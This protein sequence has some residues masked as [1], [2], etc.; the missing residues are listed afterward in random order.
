MQTLLQDAPGCDF[1]QA[2]RLLQRQWAQHP[3]IGYANLPKDEPVRLGQAPSLA[4]ATTL[5]TEYRTRDIDTPS[6]L[7]L[8]HHGLLG[9]NG[10]L[11]LNYTEY[12]LERAHVHKDRT[13]AAFLDLFHHRMMSFLARAWADNN[14]AVDFDRPGDSHFVR[15]IASLIGQ[16]GAGLVAECLPPHARLHYAGWLTKEARP[17]EGLAKIL[18]EF[19]GVPGQVIP[20]VGRW[21]R[22]PAENRSRLGEADGGILGESVILGE[23]VW[24]C[25]LNFRVVLGPMSFERYCE[26]LPEG[27]SFAR[28]CE[29]VKTYVGTGLTWDVCFIVEASNIPGACLGAGARLGHSAWLKSEDRPLYSGEV[30]FAPRAA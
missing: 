3:R 5:V 4:C 7:S 12:V 19:F 10:P 16:G 25:S 26:M 30:V 24:D 11:P 8:A 15:Y 2:V 20:F 21:L 9:A 29:W 6:R 22:I 27:R 28:L 13:M 18:A 17:P 14:I 23:T 1:F